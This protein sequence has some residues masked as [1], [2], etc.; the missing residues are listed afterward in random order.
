VKDLTLSVIIPNYNNSRFL[1]QCVDSVL[2]QSY[3]GLIEIIIVDDCSS[4][5]S[6]DIIM[7]ISKSY[8]IVKPV[9][10][11]KNQRVSAARNTGLMAAK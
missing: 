9:F 2:N 8:D 3:D 5:N 4:D 6:R 11:E 1:R 10:H 7:Y